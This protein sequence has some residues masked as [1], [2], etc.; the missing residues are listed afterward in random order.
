MGRDNIHI[1]RTAAAPLE[2]G[3]GAAKACRAMAH[4]VKLGL[5]ATCWH[6]YEWR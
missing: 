5:Y 2:A 1:A 3:V 4:R 6:P